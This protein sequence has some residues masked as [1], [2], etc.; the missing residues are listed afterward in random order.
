MSQNLGMKI[1]QTYLENAVIDYILN[2]FVLAIF[3]CIYFEFQYRFSLYENQLF[4]QFSKYLPCLT[5]S[6][7]QVNY[8]PTHRHHNNHFLLQPTYKPQL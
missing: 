8:F 6:Y 4:L 2:Y 7:L 3:E 1:L 5:T